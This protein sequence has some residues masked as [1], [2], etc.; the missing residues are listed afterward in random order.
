MKKNLLIGNGI[1][2]CTNSNKFSSSQIR[3]RFHEALLNNINSIPHENLKKH[4]SHSIN[5]IKEEDNLNIEQIAAKIYEYIKNNIINEDGY[6][7]GNDDQRLMRIIKKIA[8]EAIFIENNKFI[9]IEISTD[10]INIINTYENIFTLN[11][12]EYGNHSIKAI[13]LHGK[14]TKSINSDRIGD[15]ES[16]IFSPKLNEEKSIAEASYPSEYSYPAEDSYPSGKIILYDELDQLD[17]IDIFGVS[18]FGDKELIS[19][20][21]TINK[22]KIFIYNMNTNNEELLEWKNI[23][24]ESEYL[25]S[26]MFINKR[27]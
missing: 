19:K 22:K 15:Y 27:Q 24:N 2:Q 4:L 20:I 1:N 6:F 9:N 10:I 12:Y 23:I 8:L 26:T 16:C 14:V 5:I 21:N 7:S 11:Y 18:P 25:D 3:E 13:Y 17:E